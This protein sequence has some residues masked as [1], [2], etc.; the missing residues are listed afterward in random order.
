MDSKPSPASMPDPRMSAAGL[1]EFLDKLKEI[2]RKHPNAR[3]KPKGK[4]KKRRE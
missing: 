4:A 2:Y 1:Q 3:H